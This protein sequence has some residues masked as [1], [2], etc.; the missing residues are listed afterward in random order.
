[1][2]DEFEFFSERGLPLDIE[3]EVCLEPGELLIFDNL[4]VAHG[5]RGARQPGELHQRVI[6]YRQMLPN[7]QQALRDRFLAALR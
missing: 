6:G 2:A 5:R 3:H 1:L 7:Q 4:L